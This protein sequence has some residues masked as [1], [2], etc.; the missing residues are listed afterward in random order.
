M[1]R[2]LLLAPFLFLSACD[3]LDPELTAES[4]DAP[5]A[6]AGTNDA[7]RFRPV[8]LSGV[9]GANLGPLIGSA[10]GDIVA[11]AYDASSGKFS[12]IPVQ[13]DER[14]VYDLADAY[15][16]ITECHY[17]PVTNTYGNS[18]DNLP[19]HVVTLGYSDPQTA[20]GPD[21]TPTLD[22]NDE[23]AL[24]L[25]DFGSLGVGHPKKVVKTTRVQ[26]AVAV[27]GTTYYAYLYRR[28]H[29]SLDPS[30]RT[31][32]VTNDF[33]LVNGSYST[34]NIVGVPGNSG[35]VPPPGFGAS[36]PENTVISGQSY[37]VDFADRWIMDGLRI[38]APNSFSADLLDVDM[39]EFSGGS[40]G[41][42]PYTASLGEGAIVVNRDGPVRAIRRVVG[43]NS[44][45]LTDMTWTFYPYGFETFVNYRV[46][47]I[48]VSIR[49]FLD[50]SD[51]VTTHT[52]NAGG[53]PATVSWQ[54]MALPGLGGW[55]IVNDVRT[56]IAFSPAPAFFYRNDAGPACPF[57]NTYF[58]A[59]HGVQVPDQPTPNTDPRRG[60]AQY[61]TFR[62]TF[63][64]GPDPGAAL[65]ALQA[66]LS[67]QTT[68][69]PN[70]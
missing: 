63:G 39:I 14:F 48:G 54:T 34:Y 9:D 49:S 30:A 58:R 15:E 27:G 43:F 25:S 21:P 29:P 59:A 32:Y 8:V 70:P 65:T 45:P 35:T 61:L 5:A 23:V 40:C 68:P 17:D 10:P 38:G 44:G 62:R 51:A 33:N 46:H 24:L 1:Q 64:F 22:A 2:F 12:Q 11:F 6:S 18:C 20:I 16:G 7:R 66:P 41:R 56:N 19:G 47:P 55:A 37:S 36:N 31:D 4:S 57:D 67:V 26:V 28:S 50:L 42:T 52:Y 69:S 3:S 13:V 60:P 53:D